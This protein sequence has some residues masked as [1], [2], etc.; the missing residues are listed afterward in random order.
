MRLREEVRIGVLHPK[1]AKVQ[2]AHTIIAG[3]HGED[4]ARKADEFD[5]V[6]SKRQ[7][8]PDT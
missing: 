4:A 5:P 3:F 1:K 7:L 8:P 6:Y 2:L